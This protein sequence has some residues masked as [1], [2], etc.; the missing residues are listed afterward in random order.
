MITRVFLLVCLIVNRIRQKVL[1]QFAPKLV[2]GM[3]DVLRK[4]PFNFGAHLDHLQLIII[5]FP[6][7]SGECSLITVLVE[8][9]FSS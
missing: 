5:L 9:T 3:G 4:N 7:K 2:G 1:S 6:L 8:S